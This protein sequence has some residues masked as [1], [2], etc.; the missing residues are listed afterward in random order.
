MEKTYARFVTPKQEQT[1]GSRSLIT[2]EGIRVEYVN[3][4]EETTNKFL[5][6]ASHYRVR[7]SYRYYREDDIHNDITSG[8]SNRGFIIEKMCSI[9]TMMY[10]TNEPRLDILVVDG[11]FAGVVILITRTS[12]STWRETCEENYCVLYKDG[13]VVGNNKGYFYSALEDSSRDDEWEY[14]LANID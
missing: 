5:E 9:S 8:T 2:D 13:K 4:D 3:Y 12:Q 11:E 1:P 7:N 10:S 14:Y 6:Q